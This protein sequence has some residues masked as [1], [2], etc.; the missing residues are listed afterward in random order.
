MKRVGYIALAALAVVDVAAA[1][2]VIANNH[3]PSHSLAVDAVDATAPSQST[4]PPG[5]TVSETSRS[6]SS[7]ASST[8]ASTPTSTS[9]PP[10]S[11][12]KPVVAFLGDDWTTGVGATAKGKRFSTLLSQQLNFTERNFGA[13]GTGY[14]KST[15]T[16][17]PYSSRVA[18]IVAAN[19]QLVVVTGG[20]NDSSDDPNTAADQVSRLFAEL[21]SKLPN[22]TLVAVAPFWGDSDLPPELVTLAKAIKKGVTDAG[23]TY[24][25]IEDPIHTH[26]DY[27]ATDADP[28]NDGYAAIAAALA[29][30]LTP[31]L[32]G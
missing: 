10:S 14:A 6:A 5:T 32:P 24:I 3:A 1:V 20:R 12:A 2:Y 22:V 25:D 28:D 30:Q 31:L 7:S 15:D 18:D 23:G 29:P 21:H 8:V 9:T 27:M 17:G 11:G 16:E 13:D 26:P 19:P 4:T